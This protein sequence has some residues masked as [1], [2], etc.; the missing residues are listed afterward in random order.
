LIKQQHESGK[1]G[2]E[3]ANLPKLSI[4]MPVYNALLYLERA[5]DSVLAQTFRDF[6][7]ILVD[8]GSTD[9]SS[10]L[11]DKL[12][13]RDSR[14]MVIHQENRGIS[15]AKAIGVENSNCEFISFMDNDDFILP[16]RYERM[17]MAVLE[18]EADIICSG[19]FKIPSETIP[20]QPPLSEEE[21]KDLWRDGWRSRGYPSDSTYD[22]QSF[23]PLYFKAVKLEPLWQSIFKKSVIQ[24]CFF[25]DKLSRGEDV[26]FWIMLF[27]H[28]SN[29]SIRTIPDHTYVHIIRSDSTN[30]NNSLVGDTL[31][32]ICKTLAF[33][34]SKGFTEWYNKTYY[35]LVR[36]CVYDRVDLSKNSLIDEEFRKEILRAL[37]KSKTLFFK[38]NQE[39][40]LTKIG[41]LLLCFSPG[42]YYRVYAAYLRLRYGKKINKNQ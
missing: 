13:K 22:M 34:E 5:V 31:Y 23:V 33:F 12:A 14:I 11:C 4:I 39:P 9:G 21:Y 37:R 38:K 16:N 3:G 30:Y 26:Y 6:E 7:L 24:P 42:G 19:C 36:R 8:D 28:C 15:K 35:S 32:V 27:E 1:R 25:K 29:L 40:V 17:Y 41:L 2:Q 18:S 20:S 10:K